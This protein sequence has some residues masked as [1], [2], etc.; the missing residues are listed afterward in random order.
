MVGDD[1]LGGFTVPQHAAGKSF[2]RA[3]GTVAG[4]LVG[5][6]LVLAADGQPAI[7]V[8]GHALWLGLCAD[9]GNIL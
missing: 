3:T 9:A 8:L 6:L 4:T 7:L 5:V 2:F 1:G